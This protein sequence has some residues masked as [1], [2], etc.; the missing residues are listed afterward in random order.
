MNKNIPPFFVGQEVVCIKD[1]PKSKLKNGFKYVVNQLLQSQCGCWKVSVGIVHNGSL[2][3]LC[4]EHNVIINSD[5]TWW[6]QPS[7]FRPILPPL[8]TVTF[9]KI[10]EENPM[11]VN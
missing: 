1:T 8:Q 10:T 9:S 4:R 7:L 5:G 11:G 3:V 6:H 2:F